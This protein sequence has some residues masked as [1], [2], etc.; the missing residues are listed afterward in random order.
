MS[1]VIVGAGQAGLA[2]SHELTALGVEHTVLDADEQRRLALAHVL[3]AAEEEANRLGA[4]V[5]TSGF[6]PDFAS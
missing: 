1:V 3:N 2:V 6:R 4:V 5:F